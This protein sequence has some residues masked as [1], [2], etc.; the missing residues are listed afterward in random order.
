MDKLLLACTLTLLLAACGGQGGGTGAAAPVT[1][2]PTT[3][4]GA[5][6]PV[7]APVST[8]TKRWSDPA[9]WPSGKVPAEGEAVSLLAG[10][11]LLLDVSPPR[12]GSLNVASGAALVFADTTNIALN[13]DWIM[14]QGAFAI[15]SEAQPFTHRATITLTDQTPG[16]D[17]MGMGDR[18]LGVMGG[19]LE[20]HGQQRLAWTHLVRTVRA[21]PS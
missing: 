12:L 6:A 13:T 8:P 17:V 1:T 19:R 3:I 21:G 18:V 11:S 9:S 15:G 10:T 2:S 16:E 20:L 4:P 5:T 7:T 14:L